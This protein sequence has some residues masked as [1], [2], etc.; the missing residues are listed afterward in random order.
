MNDHSVIYVI[1]LNMLY[2][3]FVALALTVDTVP[4]T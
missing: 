2:V 3:D 4:P 1:S